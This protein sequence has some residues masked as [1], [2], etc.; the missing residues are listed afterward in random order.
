MS[1]RTRG[2]ALALFVTLCHSGCASVP[3]TPALVRPT[4]PAFTRLADLHLPRGTETMVGLLSGRVVRG[5][6]ERMTTDRLELRSRDP[7]GGSIV[8]DVS[9]ADIAF[10][11]RVVGM[12]KRARG[13]LGAAIAAVASLPLGISM[14]GDMVV[15]AAIIGS[16]IGR[17]TDNQ[18]AEV[19]YERPPV[20]DPSIR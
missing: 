5:S 6:L 2:T 12:S 20:A 17:G 1:T 14:I 19:V 10:V 16:L 13:Y 4:G 18:R 9:H 15:P 3:K 11:A 8:Y 7:T